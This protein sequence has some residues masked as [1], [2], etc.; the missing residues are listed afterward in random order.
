MHVEFLIFRAFFFM[1][2]AYVLYD[3]SLIHSQSRR[4]SQ[5]CLLNNLFDFLWKK[6][7]NNKLIFTVD[8]VYAM[9]HALHENI[10]ERCGTPFRLCESVQPSPLGYELLRYIHNVSFVSLQNTEVN[11][12]KMNWL[13]TNE[14]N[15]ILNEW[16][17]E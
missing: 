7:N 9:A 17:Y 2:K 16:I 8:A 1:H 12:S 14:K 10:K 5:Y 11:Q 3:A 4:F 6:K 13:E 15:I